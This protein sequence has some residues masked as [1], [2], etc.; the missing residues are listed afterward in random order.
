MNNI[1]IKRLH[2]IAAIGTAAIFITGC[3]G[4][5]GSRSTAPVPPTVPKTQVNPAH[6]T[7]AHLAIR[8]PIRKLGATAKGHRTPKYVSSSTTELGIRTGTDPIST[9]TEQ[10]NWQIFAISPTAP[11]CDTVTVPGY[12][13]CV[14]SVT[15]PADSSDEFQMVATDSLNAATDTNPSGNALSTGDDITTITTGAANVIS[16]TLSGIIG[17]LA[18]DKP[19]YSI[20][21][22]PGT[23]ANIAVNVTAND[24]D[25]GAIAGTNPDGSIL[26]QIF[27]DP[28]VF[29]DTLVPS[30]FTYP[31]KNPDP[32][33]FSF[34]LVPPA[35]AG[36][37]PASIT[38]VAPLTILPV[39]TTATL[40]STSPS[41]A[42]FALNPMVVSIANAPVAS[43]DGLS[44]SG[45]DII[46]T[47]TENAATGYTE[48]DTGAGTFTV[49]PSTTV[50]GTMT[51]DIHAVTATTTPATLTITDAL[52]TAIATLSIPSV[53]I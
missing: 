33:N 35:T 22:A 52:G 7:K 28:I 17:S 10:P 49:T 8:I 44:V 41:T 11:G 38:Y 13:N 39:S 51:L 16:L 20:W 34:G 43:V 5:S 1:T 46:V 37:I 15:A 42:S 25:G 29:A 36:T 24:L 32:T 48:S 3:S 47:V 30:P 19:T 31:N 26:P 45:S 53:A 18:T 21:A 14:V 23:S 27:A 12:L 40:T 9:M 2:T 6:T 50:N 4:G